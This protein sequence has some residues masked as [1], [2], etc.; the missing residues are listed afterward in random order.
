MCVFVLICTPGGR[1]S[2]KTSQ[3]D[4]GRTRHRQSGGGQAG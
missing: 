3:A 4:P 2:R 1:A